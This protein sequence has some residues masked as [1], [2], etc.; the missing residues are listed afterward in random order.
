MCPGRPSLTDRSVQ[1]YRN[2]VV[3]P[4][5]L[6]PGPSARPSRLSSPSTSSSTATMWTGRRSR[7]SWPGSTG[8]RTRS[9]FA[10]TSAPSSRPLLRQRQRLAAVARAQSR[11]HR[12]RTRRRVGAVVH[13]SHGP[14]RVE[15]IA[16]ARM[17]APEVR[18]VARIVDVARLQTDVV[19]GRRAR[20]Q[21]AVRV[22]RV[23][24]DVTRELHFPRSEDDVAGATEIVGVA[25]VVA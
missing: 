5:V 22:V 4:L 12:R 14:V 20:D 7:P 15:E 18:L 17:Y 9:K 16:P 24:V 3:R 2:R 19:G 23:V 8:S 6:A 21:V 10:G 1:L 13:E 11:K 25:G